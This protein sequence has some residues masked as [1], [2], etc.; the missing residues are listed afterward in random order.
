MTNDKNLKAI[1]RDKWIGSAE[2]RQCTSGTTEGQY[3]RNRVELAW[4][5]GWD[6]AIANNHTI[7]GALDTLGVALMEHGHAWTDGER[8]IYEQAVAAVKQEPLPK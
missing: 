5:A 4:C 2:G 3:L 1:E 8:E 6:A 7:L